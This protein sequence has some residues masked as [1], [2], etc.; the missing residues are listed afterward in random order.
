M[1]KTKLIEKES[2]RLINYLA[3]T[4]LSDKI[5]LC[6]IMTVM[7]RLISGIKDTHSQLRTYFACNDL[8]IQSLKYHNEDINSM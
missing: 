5:I 3:D 7:A 2:I 4:H 8:L 1:D 6:I